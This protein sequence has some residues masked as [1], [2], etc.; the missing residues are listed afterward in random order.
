MGRDCGACG[1]RAGHQ[2]STTGS[3]GPVTRCIRIR[4]G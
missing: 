4:P 3:A 1:P 2:T